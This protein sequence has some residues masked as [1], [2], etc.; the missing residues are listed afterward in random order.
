MGCR[1]AA[2]AAWAEWI[3]NAPSKEVSIL[4]RR[5]DNLSALVREGARPQSGRLPERRGARPPIPRNIQAPRKR[6]FFYAAPPRAA[7]LTQWPS[8]GA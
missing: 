3:C 7:I 6:G 4:K 2:W 1:R 5:A 8:P